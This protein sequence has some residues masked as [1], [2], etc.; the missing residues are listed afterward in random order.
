M[1]MNINPILFFFY[2]IICKISGF[3]NRLL[4][5]GRFEYLKQQ[6]LKCNRNPFL[7]KIDIRGCEYM[8][9]GGGTCIGNNC[10]LECW[11]E[12]HG[13]IFSPKLVMGSGC[14]I[15]EYTH[16]TCI[17]SISIG[18]G[19][20]TGRFVLISD[21]N[22]GTPG[23]KSELSVRP[24]DRP[25]SSKGGITIGNNVWIG[26]RATI[27]GRVNIGDGAI[28]AAGT[29]VTKD[30]PAGAIVAGNPGKIIKIIL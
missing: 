19:L 29:V 10:I 26:D 28:I 13:Q 14:S 15:G 4:R 20:L 30:V 27:L 1:K 3:Y 8:L 2:V 24:Q 11:D 7:V 6:G 25:L 9:I 18:D 5:I 17:K 21:N 23:L 16:I 22:H 12:Y